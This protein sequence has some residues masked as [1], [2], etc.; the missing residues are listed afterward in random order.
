[1]DAKRLTAK[2]FM[3]LA[4]CMALSAL[5]AVADEHQ[6][7]GEVKDESGAPLEGVLVC[8]G[9]PPTLLQREANTFVQTGKDGSFSI[10]V[11]YP[12]EAT[13][14]CW[15]PEFISITESAF[16]GEALNLTLRRGAVLEGAVE[17]SEALRG[18]AVISAFFPA[19][20]FTEATRADKTG[21][22]RF[23]NLPD[24][25]CEV[26]ARAEDAG[27][28]KRMA[29]TTTVRV[30]KHEANQISLPAAHPAASLEGAIR[31]ANGFPAMAQLT[32]NIEAN[33]ATYVETLRS[34][35]GGEFQLADLPAGKGQLALTAT[36]NASQ[37]LDVELSEGVHEM[38]PLTL[39][40]GLPLRCSFLNSPEGTRGI[41]VTV[42]F[43]KVER[44]S[45]TLADIR[46]LL[47]RPAAWS[48]VIRSKSEQM[49]MLAPGSY[50]LLA[51]PLA[52]TTQDYTIFETAELL[53]LAPVYMDTFS[54]SK[55]S[56]GA[57][58]AAAFPQDE[59][60]AYAEAQAP[61]HPI[62]GTWAY[63]YRGSIWSR[64]FTRNGRCILAEGPL[65]GWDYPYVILGESRVAVITEDRR[66]M[67]VIRPDGKLDVEGQF[68]AT[69]VK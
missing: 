4:A 30:R 33:G 48:G 24:G 16:T 25:A 57:T 15:H 2:T 53:R 36:G 45:G 43:G 20:G 41:Q 49:D 29:A 8:L 3:L 28:A 42:F 44:P 22:F 60:A 59:R 69:K 13:L 6:I 68:V 17:W 54:V 66:R 1:M 19:S 37:L 38:P 64:T 65:K 63:E 46:A 23:A 5:H 55:S 52:S 61:L 31:D 34:D 62:I 7:T 10:P 18:R 35:I 67:H 32:L 40:K 47:D 12:G 50:T 58:V 56:T 26:E 9:P 11:T 21:H 39:E 14:S 51:Y 27:R